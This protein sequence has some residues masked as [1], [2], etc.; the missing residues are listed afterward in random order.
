VPDVANVRL[1]CESKSVE[2]MLFFDRQPTAT[3]FEPKQKRDRPK[4]WPGR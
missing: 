1:D 3:F 2:P 4:R